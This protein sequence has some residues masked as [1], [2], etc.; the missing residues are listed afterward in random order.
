VETSYL[1]PSDGTCTNVLNTAARASD[2]GLAS[3]VIRVLSQRTSRLDMHHYEALL[4]AYVNSGDLQT[5]LRILCIMK[6]AR[7]EPTEGTTRPIFAYLVSQRPLP[8]SSDARDATEKIAPKKALSLLTSLSEDGHL[9]PVAAVNA[10]IS[11]E[12]MGGTDSRESLQSAI[13]M[14]KQLHLI[15]RDGPN[16]DTFNILLQG[17]AKTANA[18]A[19]AMFLASEM[20]ALGI[21]ADELTYDRLVLV[22]LGDNTNTS[23]SEASQQVGEHS[24]AID[25]GLEDALRYTAEMREIF[26]TTE[27]RAAPLRNGTWTALVKRCA[28]RGDERAWHLLE[29]MEGLGLGTNRLKASVV[30][31]FEARSV[32]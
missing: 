32:G 12:I 24:Q 16:T 14:Y 13:V 17:C 3:D 25:E 19:D 26:G 11:A 29:E 30:E 8:N 5:A 18:K 6:K 7:L 2:S 22:C 21:R 20:V 9:V 15:C 4:A 27:K 23:S 28:D 31:A 1:N 10:I